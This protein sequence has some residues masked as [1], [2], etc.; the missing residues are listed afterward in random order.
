MR[1]VDMDL[2]GCFTTNVR[3][4]QQLHGAGVPVWVLCPLDDLVH[5]RIDKIMVITT[6]DGRIHLG[7]CPLHLCS[8][9][10]GSG[11]QEGKYKV[12]DQFTRS[13]FEAPNVFSWTSGQL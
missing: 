9:F 1:K 2:I 13:Q 10:M 8:V 3:V 6:V 7:L 12:F 4:T 5:T 11:A